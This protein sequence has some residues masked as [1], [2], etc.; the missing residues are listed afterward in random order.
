[1]IFVLFFIAY[2]V[3]IFLTKKLKNIYNLL[4]EGGS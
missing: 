2:V 3:F 4:V 1:V